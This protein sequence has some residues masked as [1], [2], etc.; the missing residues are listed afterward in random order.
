[1]RRTLIYGSEEIV[2]N[3]NFRERK[4]LGITVHPDRSTEVNAPVGSS[5]EK[6]EEKV[7]KR[8]SWILKQQDHFLSF[9]PRN[10]VRKYVSGESHLYLGR[11]YQLLVVKSNEEIVKHTG[12]NIEVRTSDVSKIEQ[13][14]ESW[15]L[16][17]ARA[18]FH[19]IAQP[20]IEHF[21][22]YEVAPNKLE[23]R[24]MPHRWGSCSTNGRILL[25]PEL[26]KAPKVCIEYVIIHELC[27]LVHRDHTQAFFDLQEKEF[28]E[29]KKWKNKLEI[30]LA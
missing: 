6:I 11:Q 26:I 14:L 4:T 22:K 7:R 27:H 5:I 20:L 1:M 19:T 10:T 12:R 28:P 30:L 9:E 2:Y 17:K 13:L 8:A 29:W 24:K 3:L 18:W 21:K 16:E 25:N 23:I 15:Y